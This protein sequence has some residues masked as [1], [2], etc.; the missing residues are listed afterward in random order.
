MLRDGG[1]GSVAAATGAAASLSA[2]TGG[3]RCD[4]AENNSSSWAS[5]FHVFVSYDAS[6]QNEKQMEPE[7]VNKTPCLLQR[8]TRKQHKQAGF[9]LK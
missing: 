1:D 4:G 8:E 6:M 3:D 7:V 2:L 9:K 5:I